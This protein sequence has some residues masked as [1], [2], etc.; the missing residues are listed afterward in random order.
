MRQHVR[1]AVPTE[2]EEGV[3]K[4]SRNLGATSQFHEPEQLHLPNS[5]LRTHKS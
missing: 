4:C 5:I 3:Q 1:F 2:E